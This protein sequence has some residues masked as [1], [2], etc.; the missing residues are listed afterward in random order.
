MKLSTDTWELTTHTRGVICT[1]SVSGERQPRLKVQ[2]IGAAVGAGLQQALPVRGEV[3]VVAHIGKAAQGIGPGRALPRP[4]HRGAQP[5]YVDL[6]ATRRRP[7]TGRAPDVPHGDPPPDLV[8]QGSTETTFGLEALEVIRGARGGAV[9][10]IGPPARPQ[11]A[12]RR[13]RRGPSGISGSGPDP[14]GAAG[15]PAGLRRWPRAARTLP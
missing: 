13:A 15:N 6:P 8:V 11:T 4:T 7:D 2:G 10:F 9:G 5:P 1:C 3:H 12:P 14:S